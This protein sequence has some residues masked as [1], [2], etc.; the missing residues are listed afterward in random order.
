MDQVIRSRRKTIALIVKPD[1]SLLVRAP[2]RAP[3]AMI[4]EF[5]RKNARWIETKQAEVRAA[6]PTTP[7]EYVTGE[8]FP[9]LGTTYPL[10]IV[11]E[12]QSPLLLDAG[13]F[14]LAASRQ[15]AA[16]S[17]FE[18]WY[19]EQA[20]QVLSS[21]VEFFARQHGFQYRGLRITSA[22]TRWGSCS[23][24]GSLSFSW[25]LILAPPEVADYVVIHELVHTVHHNHSKRFWKGV[26]AV[27][28]D[29][30]EHRR[31]LR[32]HGRKLLV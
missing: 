23:A 19:R 5:V 8:T 2:L 6:F 11:G 16:A 1:G 26:E 28:P 25:R 32:E 13:R 18:R 4:E 3:K 17:T 22:R 7:R 14:K 20:R 24:S 30:Q 27:I 29:Y 9:Y 10:E 31:W 21:R 12:Q 15:S